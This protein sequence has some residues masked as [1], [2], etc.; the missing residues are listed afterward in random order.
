MFRTHC[1]IPFFA[2]QVIDVVAHSIGRSP[3]SLECSVCVA[4]LR[5]SLFGGSITYESIISTPVADAR[6]T[7]E[8]RVRTDPRTG[9]PAKPAPARRNQQG[10]SQYVREQPGRQQQHTGAE[11]HGRIEQARRWAVVPAASRQLIRRIVR[12]PWALTS[13]VPATPV[14]TTDQQ[15]RP[16]RSCSAP[17]P[18]TSTTPPAARG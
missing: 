14:T 15:R 17:A 8:V 12:S 4:T 10:D 6:S 13:S 18:A 2:T 9:R 16:A 11:N 7:T 5:W 1:V 3:R